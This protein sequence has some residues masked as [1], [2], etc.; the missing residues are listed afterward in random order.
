MASKQ[1]TG[2]CRKGRNEWESLRM[3]W[4]WA[5]EGVGFDFRTEFETVLGDRWDLCFSLSW[6]SIAWSDIRKGAGDLQEEI[7]WLDLA[8]WQYCGDM[9]GYS[10]PQIQVS[11]SFLSK[12]RKCNLVRLGLIQGKFTIASSG[13]G[14][15][16]DGWCRS[17]SCV[18]S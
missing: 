11:K 4:R 17:T 10:T 2:G 3:L 15:R 5:A 13:W 6:D 18:G 7:Y 12:S 16:N 1:W 8:C 9:V 14:I